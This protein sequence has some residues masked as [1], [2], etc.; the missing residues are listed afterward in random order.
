[1]GKWEEINELEVEDPEDMVEF[2][3]EDLTW[4]E[5]W[6]DQVAVIPYCRLQ[7]FI[8]GEKVRENSPIQFFVQTRRTRKVEEIEKIQFDTYL[9][10]AM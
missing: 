1:M 3:A 10:Y 9:E 8:K 4:M 2:F 7:D 6:D 5:I